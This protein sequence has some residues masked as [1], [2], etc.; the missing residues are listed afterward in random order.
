MQSNTSH[1]PVP[2]SER[3]VLSGARA[4]GTPHPKE[5]MEVTLYVRPRIGITALHGALAA[6]RLGAT[7]PA[8]R[9][10]MTHEEFTAAYGADPKDLAAIEAFAKAHGLTVTEVSPAKRS[11]VLAG[12]V[13]AF[14][15]AFGVSLATYE[16]WGESIAGASERCM[17]QLSWLR[18]CRACLA[19]TTVRRPNPTFGSSRR[20]RL[21]GE[22]APGTARDSSIPSPSRR[23]S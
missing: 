1:V 6:E 18:S 9:R 19:T 8:E 5:R 16:Y 7:M 20:Q 10:H 13:A 2:G 12:T 15:E 4:V 14:S 11:V 23:S 21:R 22:P 3:D 17:S